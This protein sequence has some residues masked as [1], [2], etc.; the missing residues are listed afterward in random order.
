MLPI[1]LFITHCS[2]TPFP[3][4]NP[5]CSLLCNSLNYRA[6]LQGCQFQ[7][8]TPEYQYEKYKKVRATEN[9][10]HGCQIE[11]MLWKGR[12]CKHGHSDNSQRTTMTG[13]NLRMKEETVE[14]GIHL[15]AY[16]Y[17][18]NAVPM[19]CSWI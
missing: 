8:A 9:L 11:L 13:G 6:T 12:P 4:T 17:L 10:S 5:F 16:S 14:A 15:R 18:N 3:S 2:H 1:P 7:H 19:S